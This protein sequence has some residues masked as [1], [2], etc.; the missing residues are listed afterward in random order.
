MS[1][2]TLLV[3]LAACRSETDDNKN[4]DIDPIVDEDGD[5][6]GADEDCDD[7][8][9]A[10]NPSA[11][12]ICDGL[13][14]NCDGTIDEGVTTTFYLD[15][16]GDDH[17]DAGRTLQA[18]VLPDGYAALS[19]D[20]DD[21]NAEVYPDAPEQCDNLDNDC[22][23]EVD[24]AVLFVWYADADGDGFGDP[25]SAFETCDPPPGYVDSADDC[26]DTEDQS[27]PGGVEI[28]DEIDNNCDGT[29][30][31]GV[32]TTYYQDTD[33][34]NYG[35]ADITT[36]ACGP[37]VGYSARPGD[38]NDVDAAI[39]PI[40]PELCDTVDN[41]CDAEIDENDAF[42]ALT[43]YA[44]GDEDGF[45]DADVPTVACA[46]PAGY[47]R[48]DTD[49][50]DDA[51]AVN[52]DAVEIC[53]A[54]DDNCNRFI[55]DD[56]PTLDDGDVWYID[57][58]EDGYGSDVLVLQACLQP[59]LYV[60]NAD[61][62]DDYSAA[63][64]PGN[65]EICD[66][67][68]NDCDDLIDE[69]DAEDASTWY[70]DGDEDGFGDADAT[71]IACDRPEG[72]VSAGTDCNDTD[73]RINPDAD[74]TWYDD[75]DQDCDAD[76]DPDP[77]GELPGQVAVEYDGDCGYDFADPSDWSLTI[78]WSSDTVGY[79]SGTSYV[80]VM[81]T[82]V[83]GQLTDDNLDG[84]VDEL[85]IPDIAYTTFSGSGYASSGYLRVLS[86]DGSAEILS[87]S[88]VSSYSIFASSGV[89]IADVDDDGEPEILVHATN[90]RLLA[91]TASGALKW[92][93][94]TNAGSAYCFP[95]VHDLDGDGDF[96]IVDC[97][98]VFDEDG[99]R[100]FSI[101]GGLAPA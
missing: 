68:D 25:D 47:V 60:L 23:T 101:G 35:V 53:N 71:T 46:Q 75:V 33:G 8:D 50:D 45:G 72:Y 17:G 54:V 10:A 28:C 93:S 95:S 32:T 14:N 88:T 44:D 38:C 20:C 49:C 15:A 48:D 67:L 36:E 91:I 74:E 76:P 3:L 26:D 83:V 85:D 52:P 84:V 77:C 86:G 98:V 70:A 43:W 30:D 19:D 51:V 96:E 64:Y 92:M 63:S 99:K 82:P 16:D 2:T 81:M 1:L 34:D 22:D 42:D 58:D 59:E 56:D 6:F 4:G 69:P 5:G 37:Q 27:F 18:C 78:E 24:E 89:A 29:V 12:E 66:A 97:N 40:A 79:S 39:S 55:D 100:L 13:D 90:G 31:E 73:A 94:D 87:L 41:D 11:A 7:A 9:A 57:Y 61:D 80:E 21:L 62:C 65:A